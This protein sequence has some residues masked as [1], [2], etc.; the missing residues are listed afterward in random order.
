MHALRARF[1]K[2][3]IAEFLPPKKLSTKVVIVCDG[4]PTVPS[5]KEFLEFFSKKGFWAFH[6]RY[7]GT[8]ESDGAF[9]KNPPAEDLLDVVSELPNGFSDIE[10][11]KRY[12][13]HPTKTFL[14]GAS[15]GGSAVILASRDPRVTKAIA[16]A[17]A[18]D[19]RVE[20]E[21][22]KL[23]AKHLKDSFGNAYRF[24][25][26][27]W[28]RFERE[29]AYNPMMQS[30]AIDGSKILILHAKDDSVVPWRSVALFAEKTHCLLRLFPTGGHFS[31]SEAIQP[32]RYEYI[33]NFM[34]K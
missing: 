8:W 17:P 20:H 3:I 15:F 22:G 16:L 11:K 12:R 19:W 6:P 25:K 23:D 2:D 32:R 30:T 28:G 33:K 1:A 5:K 21:H 29:A 13:V 4:V 7:R 31:L 14:F 24:S 10:S 34:K 18:V 26:K 27:D 9:L